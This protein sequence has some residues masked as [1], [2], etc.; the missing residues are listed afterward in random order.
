MRRNADLMQ[1]IDL[2]EE[3][4]VVDEYGE[5]S[6]E[7]TEQEKEAKKYADLTKLKFEKKTTKRKT[8]KKAGNKNA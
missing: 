5:F 1:L 8:T 7:E 4:E 3:L 2:P 6:A